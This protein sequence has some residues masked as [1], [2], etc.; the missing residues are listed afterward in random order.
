MDDLF[1]RFIDE[2][3]ECIYSDEASANYIIE[4]FNDERLTSEKF[5]KHFDEFKNQVVNMTSNDEWIIQQIHE[6]MDDMLIDILKEYLN[7]YQ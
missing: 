6:R 3:F 7:N 2:E 5:Y 1:A 4:N